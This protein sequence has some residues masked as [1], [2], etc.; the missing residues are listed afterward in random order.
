MKVTVLL[1]NSSISVSGTKISVPNAPVGPKDEIA[2]EKIKAGGTNVLF[3]P[4]SIWMQLAHPR[5][6]EKKKKTIH[7]SYALMS[8]SCVLATP[9]KKCPVLKEFVFTKEPF[10]QFPGSAVEFWKRF[11]KRSASSKGTTFAYNTWN[12]ASI[13]SAALRKPKLCNVADLIRSRS[14]ASNKL[15]FWSPNSRLGCYE[16]TGSSPTNPDFFGSKGE[17]PNDFNLSNSRF[18]G[19]YDVQLFIVIKKGIS[20]SAASPQLFYTDT[21]MAEV[22]PKTHWLLF[23]SWTR[24]SE[25]KNGNKKSSQTCSVSHFPKRLICW[26]KGSSTGLIFP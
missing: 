15:R 20:R 22:S 19:Q 14:T 23:V 21:E 4:S 16:T 8:K 7:F 1:I 2:L 26:S 25:G 13:N 24:L 18:S 10:L 17:T 3:I 11:V 12:T 9:K 5:K 6:I